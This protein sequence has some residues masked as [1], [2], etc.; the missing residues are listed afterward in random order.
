MDQSLAYATGR[1]QELFARIAAVS[2]GAPPPGKNAANGFFETGWWETHTL[3]RRLVK[4]QESFT[5]D[6]PQR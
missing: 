2:A 3:I 6:G 4:I 1:F 5:V